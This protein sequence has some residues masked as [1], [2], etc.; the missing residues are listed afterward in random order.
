M[1]SADLGQSARFDDEGAPVCSWCTLKYAAPQGLRDLA[2][3]RPS[4]NQCLNEKVVRGDGDFLT[5]PVE[6]NA[7]NS[8][9]I[10][11]LDHK[12]K[13]ISQRAAVA[14]LGGRGDYIVFFIGLKA[15][16]A[17]LPAYPF[18]SWAKRKR[19]VDPSSGI[20]NAVAHG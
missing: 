8:V 6:R 13:A 17:N 1:L 12:I 3:V 18:D 11:R 10:G 7:I 14:E 2:R 20:D 16:D 4:Q 9:Q 19:D 5:R 15:F